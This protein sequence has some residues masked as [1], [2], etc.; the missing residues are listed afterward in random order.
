M[1]KLM[2]QLVEYDLI[3]DYA[4]VIDWFL[5]EGSYWK[6]KAIRMDF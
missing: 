4:A 3:K 2:Q 5:S 6:E 1:G